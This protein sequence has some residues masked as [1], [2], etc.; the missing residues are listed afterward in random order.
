MN[1]ESWDVPKN[2]RTMPITGALMT[3]ALGVMDVVSCMFIFSLTKRAI[4]VNP[5]RS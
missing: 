2:F 4:W 1:C 3:I 5:M